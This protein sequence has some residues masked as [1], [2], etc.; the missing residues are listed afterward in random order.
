[1]NPE[2]RCWRLTAGP[3]GT[4]HLDKRYKGE[5]GDYTLLTG[6]CMFLSD[7]SSTPASIKSVK[8]KNK[9][10]SISSFL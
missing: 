2:P 6:T 7:T 5:G 3:Y 4:P 9:E 8:L 1:L 10:M